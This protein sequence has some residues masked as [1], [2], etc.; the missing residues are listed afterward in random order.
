MLVAIALLATAL[1]AWYGHTYWL[2][3]RDG[4]TAQALAVRPE[5]ERKLGKVVL[6]D[7]NRYFASYRFFDEGGREHAGRQT[8]SRD[9]YEGL[10][11]TGDV[12]LTVHY[13]RSRP[14]VNVID[15]DA[16]RW[17]SIILAA[18]AG[19]VWIA[20]LLRVVR[21]WAPRTANVS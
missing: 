3:A 8:I 17:V 5:S 20:A 21:G 6:G 4:A 7:P 15:L 14:D 12:T 9:L 13:S 10:S 1:A 11:Q 16:V 18:L 19:V 2:I